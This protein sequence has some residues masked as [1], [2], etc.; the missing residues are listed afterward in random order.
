MRQSIGQMQGT[1]AEIIGL[2]RNGDKS[3]YKVLVDRHSRMIFRVAYR[4]T[5]NEGDSEDVVQESFLRAYRNLERFDERASFGTW[6]QRIATNCSLDLVRK[7][8]HTADTG[9][10]VP[11]YADAAPKPDRLLESSRMREQLERGMQTLSE[12]ERE[13]FLM[14]H[15]EGQSIP[16]ISDKLAIG[17]SA[18]KHSVFRAVEKLRRYAAGR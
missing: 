4:I 13:A 17:I 14:R 7:R 12:Q 16:E 18:A 3:A 15:I 1:D 2:I 8:K 5:R 10:E 6:L 9:G 11:D